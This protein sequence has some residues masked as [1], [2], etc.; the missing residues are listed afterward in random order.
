MMTTISDMNRVYFY[1]IYQPL[2]NN[3]WHVFYDFWKLDISF[4]ACTKQLESNTRKCE[5]HYSGTQRIKGPWAIGRTEIEFGTTSALA[6][7]ILL[8]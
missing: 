4:D 1:L 2:F 3:V 6:C 7:S 5:F 8:C